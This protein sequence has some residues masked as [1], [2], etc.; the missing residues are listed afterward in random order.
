MLPGK[1]WD[2]TSPPGERGWAGQPWLAEQPW[3]GVPGVCQGR[4]PALI[5]CISTEF[6]VGAG[7]GARGSSPTPSPRPRGGFPAVS[8]EGRE[9]PRGTV[10]PPFPW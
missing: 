2:V 9:F 7:Q 6:W 3:P 8:H 4:I 10:I 1:G 5:S